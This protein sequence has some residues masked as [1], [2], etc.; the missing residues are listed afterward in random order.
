MNFLKGKFLNEQWVLGYGP[1]V[2]GKSSFDL[3]IF[4]EELPDVCFRLF[5]K[6]EHLLMVE[7]DHSEVVLLN[8]KPLTLEPLKTG[9]QI[10]IK[11][12]LIEVEFLNEAN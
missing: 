8:D 10:S 6:D 12:H 9:D 1:R 11:D 3:N 7:S 4:D 2:V 5:M